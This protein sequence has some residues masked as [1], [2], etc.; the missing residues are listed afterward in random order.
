MSQKLYL[1]QKPKNCTIKVYVYNTVIQ[2]Y[3]YLER[4]MTLPSFSEVF[5]KFLEENDLDSLPKS[6]VNRKLAT[7][8]N[9]PVNCETKRKLATLSK[10]K[11]EAMMWWFNNYFW[12]ELCIRWEVWLI[13]QSIYGGRGG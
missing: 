5:E 13:N 8:V 11:K 9:I 2:E 12:W 6:K 3:Q 10:A 7:L 4:L 1:I